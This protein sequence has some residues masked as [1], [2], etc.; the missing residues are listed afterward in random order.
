MTTTADYTEK[1]WL[2]RP[3]NGI[4]GKPSTTTTSTFPE[5][6]RPS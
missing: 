3:R 1:I 6:G 2:I 4:N 5:P